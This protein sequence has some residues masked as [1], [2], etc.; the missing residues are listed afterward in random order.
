MLVPDKINDILAWEQGK[1]TERVTKFAELAIY[2]KCA[3]G[4]TG[5]PAPRHTFFPFLP[6]NHTQLCAER[7]DQVSLA[8]VS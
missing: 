6:N 3:K 2:A 7:G 4:S 5:V 8:T 1:D